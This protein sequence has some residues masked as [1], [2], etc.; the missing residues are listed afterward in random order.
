MIAAACSEEQAAF[1][2]KKEIS[3]DSEIVMIYNISVLNEDCV[4]PKLHTFQE[5]FYYR[6]EQT[7]FAK[8][9]CLFFIRLCN[10]GGREINKSTKTKKE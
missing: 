5:V 7:T 4:Q 2:S 9:S 6:K 1:Q 3:I 10:S 8:E